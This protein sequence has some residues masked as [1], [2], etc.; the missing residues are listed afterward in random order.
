MNRANPGVY[1][2]EEFKTL[3]GIYTNYKFWRDRAAT[4][5]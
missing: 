2:D 3:D 1:D 4:L 5:T